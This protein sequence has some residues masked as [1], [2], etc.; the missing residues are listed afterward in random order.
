MKVGDG[1]DPASEMGPLITA[2]HRDRVASYV[3]NAPA[4]GARVVVDGR[5]EHGG[6][7]LAPSLLD[8]VKP[9]ARRPTTTRSSARCWAS[10]ASDTYD[11]AVRLVNE[12]PYG[13]GTAIFTRDGGVARR[14][15][16]EVEAGMVGHQ[17]PD[18]GAGRVLLVRRLEVV[19]VRIEPR[20]RPRGDRLLHA[21]QGRDVALAGPRNFD[22]RPGFSAEPLRC[23]G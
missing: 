23:R 21:R 8:D 20:V 19:A 5:D 3:E 15:Q 14:F 13:N 9:W 17:R 18:P 1:M 16:H 11:E 22:G 2:E 6:F 4:E 10:R 12:N 7:F